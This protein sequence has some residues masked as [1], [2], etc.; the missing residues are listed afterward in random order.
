MTAS[1]SYTEHPWVH[2]GA[3]TSI[4]NPYES[5]RSVFQ[6]ISGFNEKASEERPLTDSGYVRSSRKVLL[7]QSIL[8]PHE[9]LS[10]THL[11]YLQGR[12]A[13]F[14]G[15]VVEVAPRWD[16]NP[17]G[18]SG[19][20]K[21]CAFTR[22]FWAKENEYQPAV[23][24]LG[25]YFQVIWFS[26]NWEQSFSF[27]EGACLHSWDSQM[28]RQTDSLFPQ[29]APSRDLVLPSSTYSIGG[30]DALD[31]YHTVSS[32]SFQHSGKFVLHFYNCPPF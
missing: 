9:K 32:L 29:N 13:P 7:G 26:K 2:P 30:G 21:V 25:I 28:R 14:Q 3:P 23:L 15:L 12:T 19:F 18:V 1:P 20:C 5:D 8:E 27:G 11:A 6:A 31:A 16:G 22:P 24:V 17:L 10:T 4:P